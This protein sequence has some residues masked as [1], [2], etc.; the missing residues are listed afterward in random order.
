MNNNELARAIL[1]LVGPASNIISA[2]NCMTR[3][4][5]H[6]REDNFT[7]E[8]LAKIPGV[9]GINKM[10]DEWQ[11]VLGP[12]KATRVTNE[13][14]AILKESPSQSPATAAANDTLTDMAKQAHIGSGQELHE[15]IRKKNAT[16]MK[17]ALKKISRIF[18]PIIP[19]FIACGLITGLLNIA[20]KINPDF[21]A[22]PVFQMLA[23]AGNAAFWG[24]NLF[25]GINAAKEFGGSPILG[26]VMAAVIT[27]PALAQITLWN[28]S[29]VPG[30]GGIIAV[31][32][33]A[34]F[35]AK[36]EKKLHDII[37]EMFDLFLTPLF[38]VLISTFAAL[39]IFQPIGGYLSEVIGYAATTSIERGGAAT[40]FILG[41]SWLPMVMVGIHQGMTP[42]HAELLSRYGVTILLPILA[43][44]GG[45]Q[46]GAAIAVYC[47]T[48]NRTLKKT[49]ASALPVGIMGIGEP[50]IYGVTLPLGKPFIGACIGGACGGAIQA[51]YIVGA[52]AQ[53]LSG[54]PLAAGTDNIPIYLIG[55][56]IA[57]VTG[58]IATWLIGFEDP[59]DSAGDAS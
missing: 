13:L 6:V 29:L 20:F 56:G 5:L 48:K 22:Y 9:L 32:L 34:L 4:R 26:G 11:I 24:L 35:T 46:V 27:H 33:V 17:L 15:A 52:Y 12:G 21:A 40:G 44:A 58:F 50:L 53:G 2:H 39:F 41:G 55:L 3:L 25:V 31:L 47:K 49:V 57:Y 30:R 19:A 36:L 16:P 37:P 42:I 43:M 14:N 18:V 54:L 59:Q 10:D 45:G 28:E 7:K 51:A 8:D 1:E 23:I 38:A